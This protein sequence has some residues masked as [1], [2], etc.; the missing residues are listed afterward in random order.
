MRTGRLL[1]IMVAAVA[2]IAFLLIS[3]NLIKDLAQQER[4]RMD[5]WARA[6]ERLAK[7]ETD[8]DIEFM[9]A[10]IAQNNS[11]PVMI[12]DGNFNISEFR[13][14]SLPDKSDADKSLFYELTPKNQEYLTE[15]LKSIGGDTAVGDGEAEQSLHRGRAVRGWPSVHIL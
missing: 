15:R 1:V 11:I 7:A 12:G 6:T 4:E 13:N 2:V 10:I 9:L 14:F 3:N 8:A 5:I